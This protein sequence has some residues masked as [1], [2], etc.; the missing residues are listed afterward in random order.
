[1]GVVVFGKSPYVLSPPTLDYDL[2]KQRN[3]E[4]S[5]EL[6]KVAL[7]RH[8]EFRRR[9]GEQFDGLNAAARNIAPKL[10][11]QITPEEFVGLLASPA[12][13]GKTAR[14]NELLDG[15]GP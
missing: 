4:L 10:A 15:V 2:L 12:G 5:T 7:E 3:A 8:P 11:G 13:E 9:F 6:E 14:L 1:M